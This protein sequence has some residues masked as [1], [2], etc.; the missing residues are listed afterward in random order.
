MVPIPVKSFA[1]VRE[2]ICDYMAE[3]SSL[4]FEQ[5]QDFHNKSLNQMKSLE[6]KAKVSII[7]ITIAVSLITGL[8]G[9]LSRDAY[10]YATSLKI[11]IVIFGV[12][13]LS[14][15]IM[16]A[17]MSLIVLGDKNKVY[18]LS[19][20]DMQLS[21]KEKLHWVALYTELN[22]CL[23]IIRNNYIYAA[24]R[25]ILYAI[26][27]LSIMFVLIAA[28][29]FLIDTT[30]NQQTVSLAAYSLQPDVT[31]VSSK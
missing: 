7:G 17:W 4:T 11:L 5:V 8:T 15:M 31:Q 26:I 9:F 27:S 30:K 1:F 6:D 2:A 14:Y 10:L 21:D 13:S 25:S 18:Q 23:N 16:S 28:G 19:P 12:I 20:K 24:Y 29:I 22:V 3:Y